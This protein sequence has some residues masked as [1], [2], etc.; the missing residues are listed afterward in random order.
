MFQPPWVKLKLLA[1]STQGGY[2][3][4]FSILLYPPWFYSIFFR[5]VGASATNSNIL[6]YSTCMRQLHNVK[7]K[8]III[9]G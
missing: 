3:E 2:R 5:H 7:V 8:V 4:F 1:S 6:D 9:A